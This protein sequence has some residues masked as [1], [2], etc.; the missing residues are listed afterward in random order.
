MGAAVIAVERDPAQCVRVVAN[1]G[2]HSVDVRVEE[3]AIADVVGQLPDP[4][5]VFVGGGGT[6]AVELAA[7]STARRVVVALAAVDRV[8]LARDIMVRNGFTVSGVQLSAARMAELPG[9]GLRL[10]ATNPVLVL[11]G[12]R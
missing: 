6:G 3:G 9:G 8:A 1:A 12:V 2:A 11:S 5:S 4:D 10:A 7:V